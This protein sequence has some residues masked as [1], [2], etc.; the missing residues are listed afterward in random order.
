MD[1]HNSNSATNMST[2]TKSEGIANASN[3]STKDQASLLLIGS[4]IVASVGC[5]NC[6]VINSIADTT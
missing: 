4:R 1:N 2:Q 6:V 5:T 3:R